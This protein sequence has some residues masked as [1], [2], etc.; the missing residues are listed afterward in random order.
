M[1]SS[2]RAKIVFFFSINVLFFLLVKLGVDFY[3]IKNNIYKQMESRANA[4]ADEIGYAFE[5][6]SR[7][8]DNFSLRRIVEQTATIPGIKEVGVTNRH[9][10]YIIHN[11]RDKI[12]KKIEDYFPSVK[13]IVVQVIEKGERQVK[14]TDNE[15][16]MIQPLRGEKYLPQ[17]RSDII[18]VITVLIDLTQ[19]NKKLQKDFLISAGITIIFVLFLTLIMVFILNHVI[20]K[21]ICLF[22]SATKRLSKGIWDTKVELKTHDE[23]GEL[24]ESF[25]SMINKLQEHEKK[26]Q[27]QKKKLEEVNQEL[28]D[29]AY[30]VSHDLKAPLRGIS[31]LS[32]W[33]VEDYKDILDDEGKKKLTLLISR[34]QRMHNLIDGILQYSRVGR[35]REKEKEIDLNILLQEVIELLSPPDN[36]KIIIKKPLPS[37]KGE[38]GRIKQVFQNLIDNAIKFMDKE[39]GEIKIN[40]L[41]EGNYFR[42]SIEDNGPGI[43]KKYHEKIFQIFQTLVSIDKYGGTGIGLT[44]V[45]KIITTAGGKIWLDS[46]PGKGTTFF[47]TLPKN[48]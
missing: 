41:D 12:G 9:G 35:I 24:A 21:P 43:D 23:L 44:L 16:L 19:V 32:D 42:F 28:K 27:A 18:G 11:Q 33:I 3:Y 46:Q 4:I 25:N 5:V 38:E 48:N 31:Q 30:I 47:F 14:Y 26:L 34:V 36:I 20:I 1:K 17:Y 13:S 10:H 15:F 6:L 45:K 40:W 39:N 2:I 7:Y 29:F 22:K 8:E 37:I